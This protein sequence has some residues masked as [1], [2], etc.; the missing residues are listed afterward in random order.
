MDASQIVA[1]DRD[2]LVERV[3][4]LGP[5]KLHAV[6]DGSDA[7]PGATRAE[8]ARGAPLSERFYFSR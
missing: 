6:L 3:C 4:R 1:I 8:R 7:L 2:I 5:K